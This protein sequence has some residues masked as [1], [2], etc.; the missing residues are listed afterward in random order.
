VVKIVGG[1]VAYDQGKLNTNVWGK[2]LQFLK[3]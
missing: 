1:Q 3:R 2:A